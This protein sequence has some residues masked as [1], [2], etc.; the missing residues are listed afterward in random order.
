MN[1]FLKQDSYITVKNK[2]K[3]I[4]ISTTEESWKQTSYFHKLPIANT[5]YTHSTV[6][7]SKSK[8]KTSSTI[9]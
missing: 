2:G 3:N 7:L 4:H 8:S 9:L 1:I 5:K 6:G